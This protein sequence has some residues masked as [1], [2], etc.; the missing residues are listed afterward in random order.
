M[1]PVIAGRKAAKQ[2]RENAPRL[3]CFGLRP[4]NDHPLRH[5]EQTPSSLRAKRSNPAYGRGLFLFRRDTG[6]GNPLST[7]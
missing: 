1:S 3:D 4:R 7:T 5:C 6:A 2:S